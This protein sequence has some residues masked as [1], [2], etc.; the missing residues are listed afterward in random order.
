MADQTS[1]KNVAIREA[2]RNF[3]ETETFRTLPLQIRTQF[4][5]VATW[6]PEREA[7]F[8][9]FDINASFARNL[10]DKAA[11]E[12]GWKFG[13]FALILVQAVVANAV[14]AGILSKNRVQQLPKLRPFPVPIGN[15][16]RRIKPIRH[17]ISAVTD[18]LQRENSNA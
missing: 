6:L 12:R 5:K 15:S 16:R 13:N 4:S 10:R 3:L 1:G 8:L 7:L 11:R 9:V 17:R 2:I 18:S 14:A